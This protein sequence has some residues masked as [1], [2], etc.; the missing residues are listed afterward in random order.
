LNR[1]EHRVSFFALTTRPL[2]VTADMNVVGCR[3]LS[4]DTNI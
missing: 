3:V 2:H 4:N 1:A